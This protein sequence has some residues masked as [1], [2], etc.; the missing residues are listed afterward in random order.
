[1]SFIPNAQGRLEK[2][3]RRDDKPT[4]RG[5]EAVLAQVI[6]ALPVSSREAM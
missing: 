4:H 6:N 3:R 2:L 5:D 1:M